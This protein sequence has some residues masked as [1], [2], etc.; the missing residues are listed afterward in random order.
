MKIG[1]HDV[2]HGE[3]QDCTHVWFGVNLN[4]TTSKLH[5][6]VCVFIKQ[7]IKGDFRTNWGTDPLRSV[8]KYRVARLRKLIK[9]AEAVYFMFIRRTQGNE[10]WGL[11]PERFTFQ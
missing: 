2:K 5:V 4:V 9:G 1:F 7:Q 10:D 8:P 11:T 3:I 6:S